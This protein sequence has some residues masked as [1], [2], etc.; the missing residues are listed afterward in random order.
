MSQSLYFHPAPNPVGYKPP[1]ESE[2]TIAGIYHTDMSVLVDA[3]DDISCNAFWAHQHRIVKAATK[4]GCIYKAWT[5]I[6]KADIQASLIGL[7]LQS[8]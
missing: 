7:F 2:D 4:Q 5:N 1:E 6:S 3:A 8:L